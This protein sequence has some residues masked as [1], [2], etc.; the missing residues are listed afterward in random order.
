MRIAFDIDDTLIPG[1][2][3]F[4]TEPLPRGFLAQWFCTEPLRLGAASLIQEIRR[5][6]HDVWIYTTSLRP[7]LQTRIAFYFQGAPIGKFINDDVH[8]RKMS[9]LG[10]AFK[11][12]TKFPPAFGIDLLIDD[13]EGIVI[14]GKQ[15]G[16]P[17]IHVQPEDED[18]TATIK[19]KLR[20]D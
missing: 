20:L 5:A 9:S 3:S 6:G 14:E 18:W 7:P 12:C 13:S 15:F 19:Q 8:R 17:V 2:H 16:Y 10:S 4:P 1:M 11:H